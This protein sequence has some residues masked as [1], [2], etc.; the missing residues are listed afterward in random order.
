MKSAMKRIHFLR[1]LLK[2]S[3]FSA[4]LTILTSC[5]IFG[6]AAWSYVTKSGAVYDYLFGP[7][8]SATLIQSSTQTVSP[9]IDI[10]FGNRLLNF[11]L[12]F[13]FWAVIGLIIYSIITGA[14]KSLSNASELWQEVHHTNARNFITQR[15]YLERWIIGFLSGLVWFVYAALFFKVFLPF[16]ILMAQVGAGNTGDWVGWLYSGVG[17]GVLATCLHLHVV[18][19]RLTLLR[20][21]V[22][23]GAQDIIAANLEEQA[24]EATH[25][26]SRDQG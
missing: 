2:P 19:L 4:S 18:L 21:R 20:P 15:T 1:L 14:G 7:A 10:V 5:V 11:A 8:S 6:G 22:F 16:S 24:D 13:A 26:H 3:F 25:D 17:L 12:L 9:L 23:G